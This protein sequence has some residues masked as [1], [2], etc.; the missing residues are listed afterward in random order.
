MMP[1]GILTVTMKMI[2]LSKNYYQNT[3]KV[4]PDQSLLLGR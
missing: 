3:T 4:K 1:L 2:K